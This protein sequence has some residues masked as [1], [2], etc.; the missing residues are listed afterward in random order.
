M[1]LNIMFY[2]LTLYIPMKKCPFVCTFQFFYGKLN[3]NFVLIKIISIFNYLYLRRI[4]RLS[5]KRFMY[6]KQTKKQKNKK[7]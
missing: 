5:Q 7:L 6:N 4:V 2:R 1:Y 3:L